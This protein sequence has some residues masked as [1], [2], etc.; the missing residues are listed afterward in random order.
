MAIWLCVYVWVSEWLP[1]LGYNAHKHIYIYY[2]AISLSRRFG[3]DAR[4]L[5]SRY[6]YNCIKYAFR[7]VVWLYFCHYR[8]D[9]L[10][11][12][13]RLF[14]LLLSCE[15][16]WR[17]VLSHI[18]DDTFYDFILFSMWRW[19]QRNRA[20]QGLHAF[21]PDELNQNTLFWCDFIVLKLLH[22]VHF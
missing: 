17:S 1:G 19:R 3:S 20:W 6:N 2:G 11:C 21:I 13:F 18:K 15:S 8:H 12:V 9:F 4:N 5:M 22:F 10:M 14:G 16:Q 7:S